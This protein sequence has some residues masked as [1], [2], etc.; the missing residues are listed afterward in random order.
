M[1]KLKEILKKKES[2]LTDEEKALVTKNWDILNDDYRSQFAG[3]EAKDVDGDDEGDDDEGGEGL[4]EKALK[5]LIDQATADFIAKKADAIA[6]S[7]VEGLADRVAA[8]R[9]HAIDNG[10]KAHPRKNKENDEITAKFLIALKARDSKTL[11]ELGMKAVDTT[12]DGTGSDAGYLIPEPLANEVIRLE[13][14]G[15]GKARTLFAYHLLTNGNTKRI[16]A[17][18]S[19]LSVFWIDEGE[20]IGAS[21]PS[22]SIVTLALKK[23][24]V[25]VP[26]TDEVVEDAGVDLT[27]LVAQ[28]IREAFDQEIDLQFFMGDGTVWTGIF[29]GGNGATTIPTDELA[30]DEDIDDMRP[31]HIIGLVDNTSAAVNGKYLMHRTVL[32]KIRQLR[33]NDDGT[34][35]YMFNPLG[36]G[37]FGTINGVPVELAEAAPTAAQATG[38]AT[39]NLPIMM[40]GDFKRGAAYGEKSDI[41]LKMLDQATVTDADGETVLNLAEQDMIALRAIQRV[42]YKVTLP[43]AMRRLVTGD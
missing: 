11:R 9:K 41:R 24:G 12:E 3:C 14:V 31:S 6:K 15:Y 30:T 36:G 13:S 29:K 43:N 2:E 5:G 4:D 38:T 34:G 19:T 8:Q 32:S 35:D 26:M 21:T 33:Q 40:Y 42:G 17:L 1:L 25:I 7:L 20:K 37:D 16:T 18:G 39:A 22:F 23:L 28:L 27:G 10:G